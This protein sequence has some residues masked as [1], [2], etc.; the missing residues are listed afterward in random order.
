MENNLSA[1]WDPSLYGTY[2]TQNGNTQRSGRAADTGSGFRETFQSALKTTESLESIFQ[3]ASQRYGVALNLLK[4]IGKAESNFNPT[5]VSSA[6]AQGVMQ[7]MPATARSLGVADS[8]DA[9]SNIMGGAKY[10][11]GLLERYNGD[12]VLALSAYN[13]G[14]GNVEKY[15]GVPPFKETQNYIQKVLAY[16]GEDMDLSGISGGAVTGSGVS[17]IQSFIA[18]LE[19][20][21]AGGNV[22]GGTG[23]LFSPEDAQYLVEMMRLQMQNIFQQEVFSDEE[24]EGGNAVGSLL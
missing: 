7:L 1:Q 6:G 24:E 14:S 9:R 23:S 15:G 18:E 2:G 12:T 10:F 21:A 22:L 3:E 16:A 20:L 19:E 17:G 13:A 4:A 5:A 11:A 8:F